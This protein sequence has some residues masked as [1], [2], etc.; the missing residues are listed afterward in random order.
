MPDGAQLGHGTWRADAV[1]S[2]SAGVT[3]FFTLS[4]FLLY[5]PF[6]AVV[7]RGQ[8]LISIS[9]Y[10]RNRVLRIAPAYLVILFVTALV[11]RTANV[12]DASGTLTE[13]A[14]TDV[15]GLLGAALLIQ[16]YRPATMVIGIG[17]PGRSPSRWCSTSRCRCSPSPSGA[18]PVTR[19]KRRH[20]VAALLMP[21][22]LLL[23]IGLCGKVIAAKVLPAS[24][25][26]GY[27]ADWH[28]VVERSF[29]AQADLFAFGMLT[30]VLHVLVADGHIAVRR[31]WRILAAGFGTLLFVAS[32]ATIHQGEHSYLLQNTV[33][34]LG[35]ALV[36]AAIILPGSRPRGATSVLR[37][38]ESRGFVAVGLISYSLFLWHYPILVWLREHGLTVGPLGPGGAVGLAVNAVIVAVVAGGLSVLTYRFVELPA[39]NR[40]RPTK[41]PIPAA[42]A[43][44][45]QPVHAAGVLPR[46][47]AIRTQR[48]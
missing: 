43:T 5:R 48:P 24:P 38:L 18:Q 4:G 34:A 11:L 3:L 30:A 26:A 16:D 35:I 47:P 12:R 41:V 17:R 29:L 33:E 25:L 13:G 2:L 39:L 19:G 46:E 8:P 20:R 31:H 40:K 32:A 37:V 44:P 36:F 27:N 21:P 45:T 1:S 6:A 23:A 28:S 10:L 22:L 14:L 9:A 15:V 7:A 42:D